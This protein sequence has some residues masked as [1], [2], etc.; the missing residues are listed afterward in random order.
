LHLLSG[1]LSGCL[2]GSLTGCVLGAQKQKQEE[3]NRGPLTNLALAVT[4]EPQVN[5]LSYTSG[6]GGGGTLLG[7]IAVEN[8]SPIHELSKAHGDIRIGQISGNSHRELLLK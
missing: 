1:A 2:V 7:G 3:E 5:V 6:F 4:G 8:R